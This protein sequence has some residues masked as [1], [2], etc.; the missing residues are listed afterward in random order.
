MAVDP[1]DVPLPTL[2]CIAVVMGTA[3]PSKNSKGLDRNFRSSRP[4]K[5]RHVS[6]LLSALFDTSLLHP[7]AV[8]TS[9]LIRRAGSTERPEIRSLGRSCVPTRMPT[10]IALSLA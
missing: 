4:P 7:H 10:G 5:R 1:A 6:A 9:C 8:L 2:A 3:T